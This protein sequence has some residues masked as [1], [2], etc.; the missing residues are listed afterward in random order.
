MSKLNFYSTRFR[1]NKRMAVSFL[2]RTF[3]IFKRANGIIVFLNRVAQWLY[4]KRLC[5]GLYTKLYSK[6]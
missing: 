2:Y 1:L 6:T 3:G 4:K 5:T